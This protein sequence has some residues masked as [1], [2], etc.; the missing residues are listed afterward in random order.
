M[1]LFD[2]L[3]AGYDQWAAT[4]LGALTTACEQRAL[5]D[6]L[7]PDLTGLQAVDVGSG[8]GTWAI[9]LA[10]RGAVVSAV[11]ISAAMLAVARQKARQ[12]GVAISLSR[13]DARQLPLATASCDLASALLV[14]EFVPEP[15]AV[16]A[17]LARVLRPGGICLLAA[18]NRRSIWAVLRRLGAWARPSIWRQARFFTVT[19]L[20]AMLRAAGLNPVRRRAA[21][22]YPPIAAK[23]AGPLL[24]AMEA[25]GRRGLGAG[26]A[27]WAMRAEKTRT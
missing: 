9:A 25:A 15:R 1:A 20:E 27:F 8:T 11:D 18:L 13:A 23:W 22:Y 17:E 24:Q 19:E 3:A 10:Q 21:V 26:P 16:L 14:L 12:A 2:A 7:P 4:P 5:A 6:L